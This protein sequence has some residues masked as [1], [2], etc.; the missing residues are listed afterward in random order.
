[1]RAKL[2]KI[3]LLSLGW[4][5][6]VLGIVGLLLPVIQGVL[7]L[8][9]GLLILSSEYD[10]AKRILGSVR[11]RFPTAAQRF[12]Q[13]SSRT[14]AWLRRMFRCDSGSECDAGSG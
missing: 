7:F 9:V 6:I 3:A 13:A 1:M 12:Q 2:R 11:T 14:T 8:L 4:A 10:W 5:F